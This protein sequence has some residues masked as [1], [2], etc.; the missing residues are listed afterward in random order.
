MEYREATFLLFTAWRL[1]SKSL[2]RSGAACGS[3]L[4]LAVYQGPFKHISFVLVITCV[5]SNLGEV[6]AETVD[7]LDGLGIIDAV[8]IGGNADN[9]A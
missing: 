5:T 7:L 6:A 2:K 8:F 3:G 9:G 4:P 1:E